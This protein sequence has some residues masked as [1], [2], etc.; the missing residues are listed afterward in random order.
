MGKALDLTGHRMEMATVIRYAGKDKRGR[1]WWIRCDCGAEKVVTRNEIRAG[2]MSCGCLHIAMMKDG[3]GKTHGLSDSHEYVSWRAMK[4]RCMNPNASD[5]DSYGGRGITVCKEWLESFESFLSHIGPMSSPGMTVERINNANGAY[6]P[7]NVRWA[8]RREQGANMRINVLLTAFGMTLHL[9]EWARR[10][11]IPRRTI[12]RRVKQGMAH[13]KA[14]SAPRV[15][16]EKISQSDAMTILSRVSAGETGRAVA[17]S[18]K[19]SEEA[20]YRI[21]GGRDPRSPMHPEHP[22]NADALAAGIVPGR[23]SAL[24]RAHT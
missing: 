9:S 15:P 8:T 22:M 1:L 23:K 4:H 2:Q 6:E 17:R 24:R 11:G 16:R 20:V 3:I 14:L 13:E 10:T 5:Y 7:G 18:M 12:S 19:V 21:T